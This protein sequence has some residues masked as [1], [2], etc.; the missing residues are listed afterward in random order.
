MRA[1]SGRK[2]PTARRGGPSSVLA[3]GERLQRGDVDGLRALVSRLGVVADAGALG[4]R[5]EALGV[6]ARVV[7][8]EVLARVVRRDEAVA[9]V[10]V[11]PLD[12][13]GGHSGISLLGISVLRS[14]RVLRRQRLGTLAQLASGWF[15][16][17][18]AAKDSERT[19]RRAS[20]RPVP[21]L[22]HLPDERRPFGGRPVR[23][24]PAA[25]RA[26]R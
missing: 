25:G 6:D 8:E 15:P 5:L 7:H 9:L 4:E 21:P 2:R 13:S 23:R 14:R 11:E 24:S 3:T 12:G 1:I 22:A 16:T 20:M 26:A 17:L 10:V 19:G 18:D